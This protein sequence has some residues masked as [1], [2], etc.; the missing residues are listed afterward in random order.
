M[1]K[2]W[3]AVIAEEIVNEFASYK[4]AANDPVTDSDWYIDGQAI[5]RRATFTMQTGE[6]GDIEY[7]M[8]CM[9]DGSVF[10]K[11]NQS[12]E[13]RGLELNNESL[14]SGAL[15]DGIKCYIDENVEFSGE[16]EITFNGIEFTKVIAQM[17]TVKKPDGSFDTALGSVTP[18]EETPSAPAP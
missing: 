2:D 14:N 6:L 8:V 9:Q 16:G 10:M 15:F 13:V 12:H 4:S 7:D 3:G 1:D 11:T 5:S 17:E 18:V